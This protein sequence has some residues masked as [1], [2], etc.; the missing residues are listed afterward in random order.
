MTQRR[1][2]AA[3]VAAISLMC[4]PHVHAQGTKASPFQIVEA[5]IDDIHAAY[6]SGRLTARQLVQGYLD[7]IAA[8]DKAGPTI[9]SVITV[10]PRALEEADKLDA[11][12]KAS[13]FVGP[14]HGIPVVVK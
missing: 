4:A 13:G 14:M 8:Y 3:L 5:T 6:K 1:I 12:F 10:N 7:R 9:N 11:A 2:L